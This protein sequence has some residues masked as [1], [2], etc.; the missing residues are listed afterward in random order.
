MMPYMEAVIKSLVVDFGND[1]C[2]VSWD[3]KRLTPHVPQYPNTVKS[4]DR[5]KLDEVDLKRIIVNFQ[6]NV[7]YVSGRMDKG[8]LKAIKSVGPTVPVVMGMDN[9][10]L[11]SLKQYIQIVLSSILFRKYFT[12]VWVP[13]QR[14]YR[15]ARL[16]GYPSNKIINYLYSGDIE[17]FS[18]SRREFGKVKKV[19]FLGRLEKVKGL[20]KLLQAWKALN[21]EYKKDW[22][23]VLIGKGSLSSLAEKI[24]GVELTGFLKQ[25]EILQLLQSDCF[26]CLPS[27][28]EPW[29]VV[30]HEMAAAG[31]P[32]ILS[33]EVG[34][35]DH[36]LI[37]GYNGILLENLSTSTI[38]ISLEK[39]MKLSFSDRQVLGGRSRKLSEQINPELSAASLN[40]IWFS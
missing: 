36:F 25:K 23:L 12:H 17:L 15:F 14:Q 22:R 2:V 19:I 31:L 33:K 27:R 4:Y 9:Q 24:E 13:G 21:A 26:F 6:P 38:K 30:V 1:V 34:A 3:K 7:I 35:G 8:Y 40:S 29:G 5:S 37:N 32:L 28:K 10:W 16:L 11:G 39:L 18:H 20:D